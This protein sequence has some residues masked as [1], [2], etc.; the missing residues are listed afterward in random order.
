VTPQQAQ[1]IKPTLNFQYAGDVPVYATSHVFS[2]SGDKNQYNDMN[3]IRSAKRRGC[4]TPPTRCAIK[5]LH[6]GHKPMAAWAA[7]MRW[8]LTPTA[9]HHAWVSSRRCPTPASTAM[10]GNLGMSPSQRIERQMPWAK[11]VSGQIERL[12]DTPR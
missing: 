3:G 5:L 12:P 2:A 7:S 10:S 8:A 11:F 4:S 6:N 1:Q 9:W